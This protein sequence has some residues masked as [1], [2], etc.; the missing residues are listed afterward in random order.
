MEALE[1]EAPVGV[2]AVEAAV[3]A[4]TAVAVATGDRVNAGR[5]RALLADRRVPAVILGDPDSC[6]QGAACAKWLV[7]VHPDDVEAAAS[8]LAEEFQHMIATE[9][10]EVPDDAVAD[11]D[12][13]G[14]ITCPACQHEFTPQAG[15]VVECPDCGLFLG[16]P[17]V[18]S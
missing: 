14:P 7:L 16:A 5:M 10:G 18:P 8:A 12:A 4:G 9:V 13:G 3:Q 2:E 17:E 6:A 1:P 15:A 11:L